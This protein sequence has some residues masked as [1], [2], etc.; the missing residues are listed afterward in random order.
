MSR[1]IV[2]QASRLLILGMATTI[3]IRCAYGIFGREITKYTVIYGSGQFYFLP[4]LVLLAVEV[5]H[6]KHNQQGHSFSTQTHK[7]SG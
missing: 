5:K 4:M 2:I 3:Y 1:L 7:L 6:R